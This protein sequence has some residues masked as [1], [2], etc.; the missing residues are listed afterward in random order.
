MIP[1]SRGDKMVLP[2]MD[3]A[4]STAGRMKEILGRK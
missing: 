3:L 4:R 1:F 2:D